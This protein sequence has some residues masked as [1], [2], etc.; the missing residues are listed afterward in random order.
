MAAARTWSR[1]G[2][3]ALLLLAMIFPSLLS[4]SDATSTYLRRR[5]VLKR[6]NK[7][8]LATIQSPDGDIIDCVHIS[9]QPAFDHP[10]LK[11]HTIQ[12]QPSSQPSGLYGEATRPFTQTWNQ[13][14]EKCPD[15]TIPIRRTKEEDV[16]RATS[17]TTFGKK[18]H[19]MSSHP[20]SHLAGVTSGHYYGVA[21][22]TGDANYYGTKVT[23]N[24][25]QPTIAT[26]GDFSLSQL[27]ISA[28]SYDNKDLNTI[29]TGWQVYPAMYGDDKT[30]LF[31]YWT[32]D[33]YNETGCYNL[34]CSG[35]IQTN[36]QFVI[37]GSIS[38]V[39]TYGDTQYEYDYLV[40]KDPAGG[41]WW[42]QV[43][44]NNVGYWPS[45]IF[46]LLQTG[47]A[48]SVEWGGEVNSPQITTPM[49]S[50]HFPEEGFGKA[51]YS[52]AIQV[53]DSSNNLKPPNGVGLIAPLPSCYNVMTGS[54]ST[55]SWG[56]Y[57]YYGGPGCPQNSQI[58]VM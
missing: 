46:T 27:W 21:Y 34:A 40:W 29:E 7:P 58:E 53:V 41:N 5:Q 50:G 4:P 22:A 37:G 54:S 9:R 19:D 33:A 38:P 17:L 43:Q 13:N 23:I 18:T 32:R 51:T 48:D 1:R 26:S 39:S 15:N 28:G 31:I 12:M 52:R 6:L 45:S 10:L 25:W 11:D 24:V 56:T 55:T 8:P 49:G 42:L 57:I 35:F 16:M 44:G 3:V 14:G 36:P 2:L 30:R 47:V 20:H